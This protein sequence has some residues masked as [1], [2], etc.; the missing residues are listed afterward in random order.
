[1]HINLFMC[2][3]SYYSD[4]MVGW[5]VKSAWDPACFASYR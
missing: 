5:L 1:M 4:N 2:I 3:R